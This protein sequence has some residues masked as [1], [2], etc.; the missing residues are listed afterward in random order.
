MHDPEPDLM[1]I[2]VVIRFLERRRRGAYDEAVRLV[3][4]DAIWRSPVHGPERGKDRVHEM[5][6]SAETETDWFRQEVRRVEAR[7]PRVLVR[8]RNAGER[9]ERQL[10][11]EQTLAS[12]STTG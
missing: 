8:V 4:P 5:L 7:G 1:P 2:D 10:D 12:R 11:S 3:A 9:A 6:A